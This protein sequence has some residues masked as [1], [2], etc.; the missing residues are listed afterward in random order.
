MVSAAFRAVMGRD[1][2]E[3]ELDQVLAV[4]D[5][6]DFASLL[7]WLYDSDEAAD[8]ILDRAPAALDRRMRRDPGPEQE[9]G[10]GTP[11]LVFLHIMKVAG[12]SFSH[13]LEQWAGPGRSRVHVYLDDLVLM[14]RL[15]L[16]ATPVLTGHIP[17]EGLSL[18]PPAFQSLVV[19]R[20]PVE[21][22]LSH[23][24][25]LRRSRQQYSDLTLD[26]FIHSDV[27]D[28]PSGNYQARQLAH[29]IGVADAWITYSP[30]ELNRSVGGEP[31]DAYPLQSLFD[32]TPVRHG[33]DELL[34]WAGQRHVVAG[35]RAWNPV[36]DVT[37]ASLIDAIV[38]EHGV[39]ERPDAQRMRALLGDLHA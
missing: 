9:E 5:E 38:T 10:A 6:M 8:R 16:A 3:P 20:D 2:E 32:S 39:I 17:Y 22:T 37:P 18:L 36:F 34:T 19:L 1:P 14:S 4:A 12:T 30:K 29:T 26:E 27:Y 33:A 15:Q 13:L 21:R 31:E 7:E 11:R 35:A 28:V 25:E 24:R 23:Y